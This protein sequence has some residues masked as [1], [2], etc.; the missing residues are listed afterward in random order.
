MGSSNTNPCE[1]PIPLNGL[2]ARQKA[3]HPPLSIKLTRQ[4]CRRR[5][6]KGVLVPCTPLCLVLRYQFPYLSPFRFF[7]TSF[8]YF[9][10][11][12]PRGF[13]LPVMAQFLHQQRSHKYCPSQKMGGGADTNPKNKPVNF[14]T[15]FSFFIYICRLCLFCIHVHGHIPP[16]FERHPFMFC[17]YPYL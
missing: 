6:P 3:M 13:F 16:M 12:Y 11:S 8:F 4:A 10:Q 5:K 2:R 9:C 14:Q 7:L 15:N 17:R 1:F